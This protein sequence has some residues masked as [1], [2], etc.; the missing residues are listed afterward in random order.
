MFNTVKIKNQSSILVYF[1]S[2]KDFI[3]IFSWKYLTKT[4]F[5]AQD[6]HETRSFHDI[7]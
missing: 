4:R 2:V 5:P 1:Y 3:Q 7:Q 6:S